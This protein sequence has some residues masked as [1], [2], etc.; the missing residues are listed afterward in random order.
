MTIVCPKCKTRLRLPDEKIRPGGAKFRCSKCGTTLFYKGKPAYTPRE[1]QATVEPVPPPPAA[2]TETS[3][4]P[5]E[6]PLAEKIKEEGGQ[7]GNQQPA[8]TVGAAEKAAGSAPDE[9]E[10]RLKKV[11]ASYEDLRQHLPSISEEKTSRRTAAIAGAAAVLVLLI[12][13]FVFHPWNKP[14]PGQSRLAVER[15]QSASEPQGQGNM[16]QDGPTDK[17]AQPAEGNALQNTTPSFPPSAM[18]EERAIEIVKRSDALLK[19][20]SV[21]EIVTKWTEENAGKHKIVGWK[22]KKIDEDNY[23]VS[24][25]ALE[26]AQTKGFYF[27]LDGRSGAVQDLAHNLDLQKKL[28]I[29]Y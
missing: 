25:T 2:A 6:Q 21:D 5:P 20:T 8:D 28:N 19:M 29:Q 14:S 3:Q 27:V 23:L 7:R 15:S 13:L 11:E 12:A 10:E 4:L 1:D 9:K 24:Y 16:P 26:G 18:T 17:Q 22:A